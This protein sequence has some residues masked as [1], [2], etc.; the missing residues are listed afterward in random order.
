MFDLRLTL[1]KNNCSLSQLSRIS[2][3][4]IRT[5]EDIIA[6]GDCRFS[7]ASKIAKALRIT[8]DELCLKNCVFASCESDFEKASKL[9]PP[10][11]TPCVT[12]DAGHFQKAAE[13]LESLYKDL[14]PDI[15]NSRNFTYFS[16]NSKGEN[17]PFSYSFSYR[18]YDDENPDL[19]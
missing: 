19:L 4:S 7:T 17:V 1:S 12:T 2:G 6:R 14:Y 16:I 15:F 18:E 8:V 3:I 5:L 13:E 11:R 9:Q 10:L